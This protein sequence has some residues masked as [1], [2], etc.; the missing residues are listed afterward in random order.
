MLNILKSYRLSLFFLITLLGLSSCT[1]P[2]QSEAG[3]QPLEVHAQG[4]EVQENNSLA[5]KKPLSKNRYSLP[6]DASLLEIR[7]FAE[8]NNP[9]LQ[10]TY[11]SW[12]AQSH[13]KT[14]AGSWA[15]P[16]ISFTE[17]LRSIETRTGPMER[18]FQIS[19]SIPYSGI[20][21]LSKAIAAK[22]ADALE[23][24][25]FAKRLE[26]DAEIRK[27]YAKYY[28]LGRSLA[29]SKE[30]LVL[31]KNLERTVRS[32]FTTGAENHPDFV[33]LQVEIATLTDQIKSLE[34][35]RR[36]ALA[37]LNALLNRPLDTELQFP[38]TLPP[39]LKDWEEEEVK[40][41]FIENNPLLLSLSHEIEAAS[42]QRKKAFRHYFPDLT[43]G[44][45]NIQIDRAINSGVR[46]SG[47]DPWMATFSMEIPLMFSKIR[48][49]IKEAEAE[50]RSQKSRRL[51]LKNQLAA[52]LES[53]LF[54]LRDAK[55]RRALYEY[56]LTPKAEE[57]LSSL[58]G[59]FKTDQA[60][61]LNLI[62]AERSLLSIRLSVAK[63]KMDRLTA[64]A[65]LDTILGTLRFSKPQQEKDHE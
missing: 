44:L 20:K 23:Q 37:Q 59:S 31:L 16:R 26:L 27:T 6:P 34:D 55:R 42:I 52:Q 25:F 15:N 18:S 29:I 7:L 61:F 9:G 57:V 19:Q 24:Q 35:Q 17:Y 62:E 43:I 49:G 3:R 30:T 63:A 8:I 14:Q 65:N 33:R 60:D 2:T 28:Y 47:K 56:T 58:L 46:G 39:P 64:E 48:S 22:K 54:E 36:P 13:R 50:L 41:Y 38:Q 11:H 10:A 40:K 32:K 1:L 45:Q 5:N 51:N 21:G 4:D 12:E 53:V